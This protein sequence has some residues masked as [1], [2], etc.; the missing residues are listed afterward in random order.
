MDPMAMLGAMGAG[1][2]AAPAG[3]GAA[4][5]SEEFAR[6]VLDLINEW[7]MVEQDD[8]DLLMIEQISSLVQKLL[9]RN[10]KEARDAMGGKLSPRLMSQAYGG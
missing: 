7:R 3:D 6:S 2:G 10:A 1:Q 8:E 4:P 5:D 9:A